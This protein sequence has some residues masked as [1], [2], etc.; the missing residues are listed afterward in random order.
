MTEEY[1]KC[2]YLMSLKVLAISQ[3]SF[4]ISRK[5][6]ELTKNVFLTSCQVNM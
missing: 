2:K 6:Y 5:N 3:F 1:C 4:L